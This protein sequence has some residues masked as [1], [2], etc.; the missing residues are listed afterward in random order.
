[1]LLAFNCCRAAGSSNE[2]W[3]GSIETVA[4]RRIS[5]R[6]L[7][8]PRRGPT[9]PLY[10]SSSG[11]WLDPYAMLLRQNTTIPI[12]IPI[13]I[14]TLSSWS[15]AK[16]KSANLLYPVALIDFD[17]AC[18]RAP[19]VKSQVSDR[20]DVDFLHRVVSEVERAKDAPLVA[21]IVD[22]CYVAFLR[23]VR[24]GRFLA[25]RFCQPW[26]NPR[27]K[28]QIPFQIRD[29]RTDL[30][31]IVDQHAP[32]NFG[33][34]GRYR[35]IGNE[36]HSS[37]EASLEPGATP[38]PFSP[39]IEKIR[40][41]NTPLGGPVARSASHGRRAQRAPTANGQLSDQSRPTCRMG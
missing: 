11:D 16:L 35:S 9:S 27:P 22:C 26:R 31:W 13:P 5:K 28:R 23:H 41:A 25:Q 24:P 10:S 2:P 1:M 3:L 30:V 17:V 33:R 38:R 19:T 39:G 18:I 32:P 20:R 14:Q 12:P 8:A 29:E 37:R 36:P 34:P 4:W 7:P 40:R 15:A 6:R 21:R